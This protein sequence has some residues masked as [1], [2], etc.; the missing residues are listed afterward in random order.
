MKTPEK[1]IEAIP[2]QLYK[3]MVENHLQFPLKVPAVTLSPKGRFTKQTDIPFDTIVMM[4]RKVKPYNR[5]EAVLEECLGK[6]YTFF[7]ILHN[8]NLCK[9]AETWLEYL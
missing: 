3:T 9:V 1:R 8:G 6:A 2:G 7:I 5:R 4:V